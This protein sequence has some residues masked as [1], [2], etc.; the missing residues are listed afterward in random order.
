[1]AEIFDRG[2]DPVASRDG[3]L[4]IDVVVDDSAPEPDSFDVDMESGDVM[5]IVDALVEAM[6]PPAFDANL[7][8]HIDDKVK[9]ETINDLLAKFD[10]DDQARQTWLTQYKEAVTL[11]GLAKEQKSVP[12]PNACG[13]VHSIFNESVL[14]YQAQV[15]TAV[16]PPAGPAKT[17]IMGR[18]NPEIT[19]A[20]M[21]VGNEL[22]YQLT[23]KMPGARAEAEQTFLRCGMSGIGIEKIYYDSQ[24]RVPK[25][26]CIPADKVLLPSG[27][28]CIDDASRIIHIIDKTENELKKDFHSGYYKKVDLGQP[29]LST[30]TDTAREWERAKEGVEKTRTNDGTYEILEY[31]IELDI[32]LP[33][34][35]EDRPPLRPFVVTIDK[36]SEQM[37]GFR[38]NWREED[39][40]MKRIEYF[41][42]FPY[43]PSLTSPYGLGLMHTIGGNADAATKMLRQAV[44]LGT[45]NA[46][47]AGFK[48][49]QLRWEGDDSPVRPGELRDVSTTTQKIADSIYMMPTKEVSQTHLALM[50]T[51]VEDARRLASIPDID[52]KAVSGEVPVGTVMALIEQQVKIESATH[53]RILEAMQKKLRLVALVIQEFMGPEYDYEDIKDANRQADFALVMKYIFPV[54]DPNLSTMGMRMLRHQGVM[55]QAQSAPQMYDM[56]LLHKQGLELMG[57]QDADK[58]LKIDDVKPQ[59]PM[60][61]NMSVLMQKPIKVFP[62]QDHEAHIAVHQ[63]F[64]NDP[65]LKAMVGQSPNAGSMMATMEAH[66]AEHLAY[67]YRAEMSRMAGVELPNFGEEFPPE[68]ENRLSGV[69]RA[70]ADKLL[71]KNTL[72]QQAQAAQAAANDPIV[73]NQTRE[74]DIKERKVMMDA[75]DK[76]A[77]RQQNAQLKREQMAADADKADQ[78]NSTQLIIAAAQNDQAQD[79]QEA[80][81]RV[82]AGKALGDLART[83]AQIEQSNMNGGE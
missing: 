26:K 47:P 35:T 58:M 79:A 23:Q 28:T 69:V 30:T 75:Q 37:L 4:M 34:D 66:L 9:A 68:V 24:N 80:S 67:A 39:D 1:M 57:V 18:E 19:A 78:S 73:Q 44:D 52:S 51:L 50:G 15:A 77:T 29:P 64:M 74:L 72:E 3:G 63:A 10:E 38:R 62:H 71:Q 11:L 14:R 55:Q 48:S 82:A 6:L 25:A 21:R 7:V 20:A 13:T 8:D 76:A 41:V 33:G 59:D 46:V 16:W 31:H 81:N 61:E 5:A 27:A 40:T 2:G 45:M 60:S 17:K 70:A 32:D 49:K 42:G 22:N 43:L 54:A 36:G 12:W 83:A 53:Q 65:K 56:Q